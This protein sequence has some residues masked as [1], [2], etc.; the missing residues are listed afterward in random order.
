MVWK[1][2]LKLAYIFTILFLHLLLSFSLDCEDISN[3]RDSVSSHFQ[4]PRISS[5][6]AVHFIFNSL[7]SVW[8]C[9]ETL[10]HVW[11][12]YVLQCKYIMIK[13]ID[14]IHE[15]KNAFAGTV[16]MQM[17]SYIVR[18]AFRILKMFVLKASLFLIMSKN[19]W[20]KMK[21][22]SACRCWS[23]VGRT[24]KKQDISLARGCWGKGTVIHEIGK[25]TLQSFVI[26]FFRAHKIFEISMTT[27]F[28]SIYIVFSIYCCHN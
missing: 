25:F 5:N 14:L 23:Y 17:W 10:S 13:L 12:K 15:F 24:G 16:S 18:Y 21:L 11:Y 1:C 6:F 28:L 27:S 26:N 7:L 2:D 4:T 19:K 9:D 3:T 22:L 8:K 20:I